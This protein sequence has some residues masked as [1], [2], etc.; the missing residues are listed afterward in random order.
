MLTVKYRSMPRKPPQKRNAARSRKGSETAT[1]TPSGRESEANVVEVAAEVTRGI[2]TTIDDLHET[3]DLHPPDA[4]APLPAIAGLPQDVR[5]TPTYLVAKLVVGQMRDDVDHLLQNDRVRTRDLL[6]GLPHD[7]DIETMTRRNQDVGL[8]PQVDLEVLHA[9]GMIETEKE[10]EVQHAVIIEI[11]PYHL[12]IPLA[13]VPPEDVLGNALLPS[14]PAVPHHPLG[15][16][17][18]IE[19]A[20]HYPPQSLVP[21]P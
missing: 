8:T 2:M 12:Q 18:V 9:G 20:T 1:L 5:S 19:D 13:H 7:E 16:D 15:L 6:Q 3:R 14:H 4:E 21:D 11:D 10:N 17:L